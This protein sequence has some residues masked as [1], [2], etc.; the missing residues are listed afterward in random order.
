MGS[1]LCGQSVALFNSQKILGILNNE[2]R[3]ASYRSYLDFEALIQGVRIDGHRICQ[4]TLIRSYDLF[5][6]LAFPVIRYFVERGLLDPCPK[7]PYKDL[8][9]PDDRNF[10]ASSYVELLLVD[11]ALI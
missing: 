4:T 8:A 9:R 7:S 11:D 5:P 10:E 2:K 6:P 1:L 3:S